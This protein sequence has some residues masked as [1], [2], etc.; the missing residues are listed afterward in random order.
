[1]SFWCQGQ[2]FCQGATR[3]A[4]MH[5]LKTQ[6]N[7]SSWL[8]DRTDVQDQKRTGIVRITNTQKEN[9]EK[10]IVSNKYSNIAAMSQCCSGTQ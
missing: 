10:T 9:A 4:L 8:P 5:S 2:V 6:P 7:T 3:Q 1:M